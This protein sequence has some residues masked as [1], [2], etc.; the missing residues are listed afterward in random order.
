MFD[1]PEELALGLLTGLLFGFLLQKG[2]AAKYE[3]IMGQLLLK[4]WTVAQIM[5]T[6]VAVG[7][8]GVYAIVAWGGAELHVRPADFAAL[9][10]GGILF[11]V[12]L[13]VVGLCP[14]TTVAAWG[15]GRRDAGFGVLGMLAGAGVYVVAHAPLSR[16]GDS[17]GSWGEAT[18]PVLTGTPAWLWI[19]GIGVAAGTAALA[20]QNRAVGDG[21][22]QVGDVRE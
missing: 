11:G 2:Q 4:R 12:G 15:Q 19:A 20:A 14:G 1:P 16:L 18:L 22:G 6:A 9:L 3:V 10:V 13:A 17:L 8:P 21:V 7:A 5:L